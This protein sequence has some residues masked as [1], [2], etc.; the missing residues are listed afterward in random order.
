MFAVE[1]EKLEESAA[2]AVRLFYV[3]YFMLADSSPKPAAIRQI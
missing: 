1:I 3:E 2:N